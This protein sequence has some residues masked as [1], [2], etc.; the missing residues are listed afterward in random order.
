MMVLPVNV[1]ARIVEALPTIRHLAH[2]YHR[3]W[4]AKHLDVDDLIAIGMRAL[5]RALP[6]FNE[7]RSGF[8]TYTWR[9]VSNALRQERLR[10]MRLRRVA[11]LFPL[12]NTEGD[13]IDLTC[14]WPGPERIVWVLQVRRLIEGLAPAHREVLQRRVFDEDT[15]AEVGN[16]MGLT[17][18]RVRQ[19]ERD[20][21]DIL[22]RR[23]KRGRKHR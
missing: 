9:V 8:R 12:H 6:E 13:P 19:I 21:L 23:I 10:Y 20:A 11:V 5:W 7:K 16:D 14:P 1:D 17:R 3:G 2:R 4:V 18:E 22:E 15:L